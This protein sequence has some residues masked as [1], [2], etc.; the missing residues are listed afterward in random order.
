[1]SQAVLS[2]PRALLLRDIGLGT[3]GDA[4]V[5]LQR[6]AETV[7]HYYRPATR[8]TPSIE[9]TFQELAAIWW[10]ETRFTSSVT[11]MVMHMAYQRIIGLGPAVIPSLLQ[12]LDRSPQHWFWALH[13]ITG[14]DPVLPEHKGQVQHMVQDWLHWGRET[15][16]QW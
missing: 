11:A 13:A 8:Q 5:I 2:P 9:Q 16:Y 12:E 6:W 7:E 4:R 14:V 10:E 1:M 3:G 15:G